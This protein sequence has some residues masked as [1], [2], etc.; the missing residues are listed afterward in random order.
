MLFITSLHAENIYSDGLY[1]GFDISKSLIPKGD[2]KSGGPPRDGIPAIK[3]PKFVQSNK[4]GWLDDNDFVVGVDINGKQKAYPIRILVWH[5]AVDDTLGDIPVLV[6]YCP[7]CGSAL[8]FNRMIDGDV[9][10]FG[11]S[12]LLYQSDVLLYDH[13]NESLWSQLEMKAVTGKKLGAE[14]ELIPSTFSTWKEW[15]K[16]YPNTLVL[17]KVTGYSRNYNMDPYSDYEKSRSLIFPVKNTSN[18]FHPK[19]KVLVVIVD[20]EAKAYPFSELTKAKTPLKDNIKGKEILIKFKD[21]KFINVTDKEKNTVNS[22]VSYWFAW[23]TFSP[24]TAVF[25]ANN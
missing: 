25:T 18:R 24:D 22:F 11:I 15:R 1:N 20:D 16:N 17:S 19:E 10:T 5:E 4:A 21:G 8:V 6:T 9:L 23:Y 13:Q 14:F 2:I 3:N 12:G 7:L